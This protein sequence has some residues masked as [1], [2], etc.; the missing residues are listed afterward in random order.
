ML[1]RFFSK[2]IERDED[3]KVLAFK[4]SVMQ[5]EENYQEGNDRQ[6]CRSNS[7]VIAK[8]FS[9][10]WFK[11]ASKCRMLYASTLSHFYTSLQ[12]YHSLLEGSVQ[13]TIVLMIFL[14][15]LPCSYA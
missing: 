5:L 2:R 15:L 13:S 1:A 10:G 11:Y 14:E 9:Q 3:E 7:S 12:R 6:S 8:N 4:P